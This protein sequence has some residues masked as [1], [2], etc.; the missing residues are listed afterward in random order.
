MDDYELR[1][2][3][4]ARTSNTGIGAASRPETTPPDL[5]GVRWEAAVSDGHAHGRVQAEL[6]GSV[7]GGR[8]MDIHHA[9][10]ETVIEQN[11][12]R[13]VRESRLDGLIAGSPVRLLPPSL[14]RLR[15]P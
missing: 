13:L 7:G 2:A 9:A 6:V 1:T 15:E 14:W 3:A 4:K 11:T 12:G 8:G 5:D 10:L